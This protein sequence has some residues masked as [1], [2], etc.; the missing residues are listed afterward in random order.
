MNFELVLK[1]ALCNARYGRR[2]ML[3]TEEAIS[4]TREWCSRLP[5]RYDLI[6]G[7]PRAGLIFADFMS[8]ELSIPLSVPELLPKYWNPRPIDK[9]SDSSLTEGDIRS[10]LIVEDVTSSGSRLL[11]I[12]ETVKN[13][14]PNAIVHIGALY[15]GGNAIPL[16]S[17]GS[18]FT[19]PCI[20]EWDFLDVMFYRNMATDM[21]GVLCQDCPPN[22]TEGQ[23][24]QWMESAVPHLLPVFPVTVVTSR[25]MEHRAVTEKWLRRNGVEFS[26]LYMDP[27]RTDSERDLVGWKV[28]IIN[29]I[30]PEVFIESSDEM[31]ESIHWKTGV[32][33]ICATTMRMYR[34]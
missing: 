5:M 17:Y 10:I 14:F 2:D 9:H 1:T 4:L 19:R 18:K 3:R 33:V 11:P 13:H 24:I 15:A 25:R 22:L 27:A 16:D 29:Q 28:R 32:P 8:V 7:V 21:D 23:Y 31:A 12:R 20:I 26:T 34:S 30:K 6:V